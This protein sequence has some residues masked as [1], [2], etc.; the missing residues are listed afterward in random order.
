M[1]VAVLNLS[2][3]V[4]K[5]T[6][7]KY[8]LQPRL[9]SEYIGVT[10][11]ADDIDS[12]KL[13]KQLR[14]EDFATIQDIVLGH[15]N[16][17][18][19]VSSSQT[20]LFLTQMQKYHGSYEDYQYFIV[21]T[22][23]EF[24]AIGETRQTLKRLLELGIESGQIRIIINNRLPQNQDDQRFGLEEITEIARQ[25]GIQVSTIALELNELYPN[26]VR[27]QLDFF[28]LLD[29]AVLAKAKLEVGSSYESN[30]DNDDATVA[31]SATDLIQM[32]SLALKAQRNLDKIFSELALSEL[33]LIE[34]VGDL[35]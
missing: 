3:N 4:G 8:L 14:A 10:I 29:R 33:G 26:L 21:P 19:D 15:D 23:T 20:D 9:N 18:V 34:R 27:Y 12:T 7:V 32:Q 11:N 25:L 30:G 22:T 24:K 28:E 2:A 17:T 13:E 1:N 35:G 31:V 16:I 5:T 6:L